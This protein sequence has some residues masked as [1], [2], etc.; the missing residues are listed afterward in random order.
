MEYNSNE[1]LKLDGARNRE[2]FARATSLDRYERPIETIEGKITG[3][4][5][6]NV[7]G[8]SAVRRSFSLTMVV[9]DLVMH[10]IYWGLRHKIK[11]EIGVRDLAAGPSSIIYWFKQ[12]IYVLTEFRSTQSVNNFTIS[13]SGKDKMC[14]LNG[15][16]GGNF[17]AQT[18]VG[19]IETMSDGETVQIEALKK[20]KIKHHFPYLIYMNININILKM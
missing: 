15:E 5:S 1:L 17:M 13:M 6:I 9:K 2:I 8:N 20:L 3:S 7:D 18:D 10:N 19:Q 16:V 12:G 11:L 4:G 14:L